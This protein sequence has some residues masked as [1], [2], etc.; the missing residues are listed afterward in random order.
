MGKKKV[1][2]NWLSKKKW[3]C[4]ICRIVSES[5]ASPTDES[6]F[7]SK[8]SLNV[9]KCNSHKMQ[10]YT[11]WWQ[12]GLGYGKRAVTFGWSKTHQ[13][14]TINPMPSKIWENRLT[15]HRTAKEISFVLVVVRLRSNTD[16]I[17]SVC[18]LRAV[19]PAALRG[20]TSLFT[21]LSVKRR[22]YKTAGPIQYSVP[23]SITDSTLPAGRG[24]GIGTSIILTLES[25]KY[26][27]V[28]NIW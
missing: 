20:A 14:F 28:F 19:A 22:A 24:A 25:E 9:L 23:A 21:S 18:G 15:K 26:K 11:S 7:H 12:K 2:Q 4:S 3:I 10:Y 13:L 5:E 8:V 16:T 1:H 17:M 6:H 27:A